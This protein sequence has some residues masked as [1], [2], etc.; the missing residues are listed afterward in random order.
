MDSKQMLEVLQNW[1][2]QGYGTTGFYKPVEG[3]DVLENVSGKMVQ[4]S[5]ADG[6]RTFIIFTFSIEGQAFEYP[7]RG[8]TL[9]P[10]QIQASASMNLTEF[11]ATR[12]WKPEGA[13][14]LALEKGKTKKVFAY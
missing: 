5:T 9:A 1:G 13:T 12:D 8:A 6:K 10:G 2:E 14:A 3:A 11:V 7:V 4:R